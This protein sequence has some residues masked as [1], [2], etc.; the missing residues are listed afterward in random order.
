[1]VLPDGRM[2]L[3]TTDTSTT[4]ATSRFVKA[5]LSGQGTS[6]SGGA[7]RYVLDNASGAPVM[8]VVSAALAEKVSLSGTIVG[9]NVNEA[10]AL[11]YLSRYDTPA[12]LADFAGAWNATL[13]PG[14]V[15]WDIA[16]NGALNGTR[17]TGCTYT[18]QVS[19]R[20][21]SKAIVAV[22]IAE[23]C[24]GTVTNL[25]G[26]GALSADKGHITL[27]MTSADEATAV[28]IRLGH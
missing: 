21:E 6:F 4:P 15:N 8:V 2:W 11:A 9:T 1:M 23:D 10:Y 28:A 3:V 12:V 16:A 7:R 17:T 5:G 13:G 18:G 19:L 26:V 25:A 24:A 14:T 27:F 20:P 22:A